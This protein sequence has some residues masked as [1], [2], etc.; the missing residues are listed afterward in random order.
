MSRQTVGRV[1]AGESTG[2]YR[3][4]QRRGRP[5]T[6]PFEAIVEDLLKAEQARQT[7]RK[8]RLTAKRIEEI[9]R[10]DHGFTG[11]EASA[12][13][14]V[15]RVRAAMGDLL[16]KAMVPLVYEP[17][18][19]GQVDFLEADVDYPG[20]RRRCHFLLVRACYSA[21]PFVYHAPAQNQEAVLEG[22]EQAFQHFGGVFHKLWFD[23]LTPVVRKVLEGRARKVQPRFAA[24][25][26]HYG[27]ESEFCAPGKGNEKGGVENGVGYFRRHVL[28]PVPKVSGDASLAEQLAAWMIAEEQRQPAGRPMTISKLWVEEAA[29]LMPLPATSFTAWPTSTRKVSAYSLVQHGRNFYSV[30]ASYVGQRLTL[31]QRARTVEIYADDRQVAEHQRHYGRDEVAFELEHYLPLLE[32][33][34]R[35]FDRAAPIVAVRKSWPASYEQL[36]R[37]LR[38]REGDADG[39]RAFIQILKLHSEHRLVDI[40]AAVE[41]TLTHAAPSLTLVRAHL[42][43]IEREHRPRVPHLADTLSLPL[44]VVAAPDL[45]VYAQLSE[46]EVGQ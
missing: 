29:V 14:V 35:A 23:N 32:R 7:P 38:L 40:H 30:P 25:Q 39:T 17:G 43:G 24:F 15:A 27:F 33:K 44:V 21:R 8:Q 36:L 34:T 5:V 22:L 4:Q 26:A 9:L 3:Q 6:G 41:R 46:V 45:S 42:D 37:L 16:S 18:I 10:R 28:S 11:G 13:R 20:G 1:L 19:D 2:S 12:R 31:K